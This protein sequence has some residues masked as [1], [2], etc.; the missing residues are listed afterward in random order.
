VINKV[1]IDISGGDCE[2]T[3]GKMGGQGH[4][5]KKLKSLL[6]I[7]LTTRSKRMCLDEFG[8]SVWVFGF[9]DQNSI[10]I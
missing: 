8:V 5:A 10:L 9:L 7:T 3:T 2:E 6:K 1:G 4:T